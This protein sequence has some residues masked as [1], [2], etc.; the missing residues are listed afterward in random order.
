[1]KIF[2]SLSED[3]NLAEVYERFEQFESSLFSQIEFVMRG[4]SEL[5]IGERELIA[6]YTSILNSCSFCVG[7]HAR[8]ANAYG[9]TENTI[10]A[11]AD[12]KFDE[13]TEKN[14]ELFK[15]I[16]K[17]VLHSAKTTQKGIDTLL[18]ASWSEQA[19]FSALSVCSLFCQVN[20][21]VNATGCENRNPLSNIEPNR[22]ESYNE[23]SMRSDVEK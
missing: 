23:R 3:P 4:E 8:I 18:E 17:I 1:M 20:R 10:V 7:A 9:V 15:Y 21:I 16:K 12:D 13:L 19:I 14:A 22:L 11:L 5:S 6:A 2:P